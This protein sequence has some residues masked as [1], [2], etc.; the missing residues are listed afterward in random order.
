ML[1]YFAFP[2]PWEGEKKIKASFSLKWT[3]KYIVWCLLL[4]QKIRQYLE[5]LVKHLSLLKLS[6]RQSS[7]SSV[8]SAKTI[9]NKKKISCSRA[10]FTRMVQFLFSRPMPLNLHHWWYW[11]LF[12]ALHKMFIQSLLKK[13]QPTHKSFVKQWL[14][15]FSIDLGRKI[16][17]WGCGSILLCLGTEV[18]CDLGKAQIDDC[19]VLPTPPSL[20]WKWGEHHHYLF[21]VL[22]LLI[23]NGS[24]LLFCPASP[25]EGPSMQLDSNEIEFIFLCECDNE[26]KPTWTSKIF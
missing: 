19:S 5:S 23:Y 3:V 11:K 6:R 16:L 4:L 2:P 25:T 21:R 17:G 9:A 22:A 26:I 13:K 14:Q 10:I 12:Q 15:G 18:V 20:S 8:L 1:F 7:R 24:C